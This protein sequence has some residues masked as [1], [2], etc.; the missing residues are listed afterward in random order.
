MPKKDPRTIIPTRYLPAGSKR[1]RK[2]DGTR[3][4]IIGDKEYPS[5]RAYYESGDWKPQAPK[6][7]APTASAADIMNDEEFVDAAAVED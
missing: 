2:A 3:V 4:W 5:K 7:E 6:T 1:I